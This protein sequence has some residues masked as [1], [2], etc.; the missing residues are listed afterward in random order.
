MTPTTHGP[1]LLEDG[2]N[3]LVTG[4]MRGFLGARFRIS[5][6]V[7]HCTFS[8]MPVYF[9]EQ[10][11]TRATYVGALIQ[12]VAVR[13]FNTWRT[14]TQTS[15]SVQS[16][17]CDVGW[18]LLILSRVCK[19]TAEVNIPSPFQ[20]CYELRNYQNDSSWCACTLEEKGNP[21]IKFD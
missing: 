3:K 11:G 6:A 7:H 2:I 8:G 20:W 18:E 19:A 5:D 1:Q 14:H 21:A 10:L 4:L 17:Y 13:R 12:R 15:S 9:W 16:G